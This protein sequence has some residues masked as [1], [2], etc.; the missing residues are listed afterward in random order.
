MNK[1]SNSNSKKAVENII[2]EKK[3]SRDKKIKEN[4]ALIH[5]VK[6]SFKDLDIGIKSIQVGNL[7]I[8]ISNESNENNSDKNN[9]EL[10]YE[11]LLTENKPLF[12]LSINTDNIGYYGK[13][14]ACFE[15]QILSDLVDE[16]LIYHLAPTCKLYSNNQSYPWKNDM[17]DTSSF[18]IFITDENELKNLWLN[19]KLWI[20]TKWHDD[21]LAKEKFFHKAE[22]VYQVVLIKVI[23]SKINEKI[24]EH[25]KKQEEFEKYQKLN[26]W[27]ALTQQ[28]LKKMLNSLVI[29]QE[30]PEMGEQMNGIIEMVSPLL[31]KTIEDNNKLKKLEKECVKAKNTVYKCWNYTSIRLL[32]WN[33]NK[34]PL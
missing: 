22:S 33:P 34:I 7:Q 2:K 30:H 3:N 26:E 12:I 31:S 27:T 1:D 15:K 17:M 28:E 24:R 20:K 18:V 5:S 9:D 8:N 11:K 23:S 29:L 25:K 14:K 13:E 19:I 32:D 16:K 4:E 6:Q 10:H 21:I